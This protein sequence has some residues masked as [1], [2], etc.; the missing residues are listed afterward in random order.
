M[1]NITIFYK[2]DLSNGKFSE[3]KRLEVMD[4]FTPDIYQSVCRFD[5]KGIFFASGTTDGIL[6]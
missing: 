6:K 1:D 5:N 3:L 4:R 2:L